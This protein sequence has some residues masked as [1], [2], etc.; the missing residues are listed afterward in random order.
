MRPSQEK[1]PLEKQLKE[2]SIQEI[3]RKIRNEEVF[4]AIAED[5]SFYIK[6]NEYLPYMCAAIHDGG[7]LR[8]ELKVKIAHSE[9]DRWYEEDPH[10][11]DFIKNFPIVLAGKDSR[12]EYDL[13]RDPENCIFDDA[14]GKQVWKKPLKP[15][16][17]K[18]SLSKHKAFYQV[19]DAL[20]K[21]LERKFKSCIVFDVHSY[22]Y[23]RHEKEVPLFNVGTE[24]ID[25]SKYGDTVNHF[26]KQL[27]KIEISH[28]KNFTAENGVFFGRGYFLKHIT[29]KCKNTLVLATEVKKVYCNEETGESFPLVIDEVQHGLSNAILSTAQQFVNS[30]TNIRVAKKEELLSDKIQQLLLQIDKKLHKLVKNFELLMYVNPVNTERERKKFMAARGNYEPDFKYKPININPFLMK[31]ELHNLPIEKIRDKRIKEM[32]ADVINAYSRKIDMLTTIGTSKFLSNSVHYFG[33][34]TQEDLDNARF[35]LHRNHQKDYIPSETIKIEAAK[36]I[37]KRITK[38]YGFDCE[39]VVSDKIT[40]KALVL[41]SK[42]QVVLKKGAEYFIDEIEGL[43]HHEVGVHMVTTQ[44]SLLQPLKIFNIGLPVN[45]HTQEG[46]AIC[47]EYYSGNLTIHRLRELALRVI[48]VESMVKEF[49]F[50]RTCRLV[51]EK[52]GMD[53]NDAFYLVTRVFRGG[54]FPKDFLYLSG[55]REVLRFFKQGVDISPLLIGKVHADY[56]PLIVDLTERGYLQ[57]PKYFTSPY[58]EENRKTN[59]KEVELLVESML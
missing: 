41:N 43:V 37:F 35:I 8:E 20:T 11:R 15:Q 51:H 55:F 57:Q 49:N 46:L 27:K 30:R 22:N 36:D 45:T 3:I 53:A 33:L 16:E 28:T 50:Q 9:Y 59:S 34:P 7:Q 21:T 31:R 38:E 1:T 19:V 6:I 4:A 18:K 40:S 12:F 48:A 32:Y 52:Y 44:N 23:V 13:N 54:G 14:W 2:L 47:S 24:N 26:L 56:M 39:I 10:T 25:R 17:R 58:R 5:K 29:A 42:K